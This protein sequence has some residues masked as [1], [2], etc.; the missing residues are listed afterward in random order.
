VIIGPEIEV[1]KTKVPIN[2][3]EIVGRCSVTEW[4]TLSSLLVYFSLLLMFG[5]K[6]LYIKG[7]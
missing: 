2:S 5:M 3:P 7:F 1:G 4:N 6:P